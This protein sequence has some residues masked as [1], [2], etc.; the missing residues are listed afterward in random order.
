MFLFVSH[1]RTPRKPDDYSGKKSITQG[2][3]NQAQ[4][5]V[6]PFL[7]RW[8]QIPDIPDWILLDKNKKL[9]INAI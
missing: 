3:T 4:H 2:C 6:D 7:Q 5:I 1:N 8:F 9:E